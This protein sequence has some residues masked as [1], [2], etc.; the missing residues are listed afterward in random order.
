MG[1]SINQLISGAG[2][3][4]SAVHAGYIND[5]LLGAGSSSAGALSGGPSVD[6][7][8]PSDLEAEAQRLGG[9]WGPDGVKIAENM[10]KSMLMDSINASNEASKRF[11][12]AIQ[13]SD[14]ER[15]GKA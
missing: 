11:V 5:P 14:P 8:L 3:S 10:M 2:T 7:K 13:E 6:F 4:G 1:L 15:F 12:Q 9:K